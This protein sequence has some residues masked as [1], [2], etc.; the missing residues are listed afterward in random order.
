MLSKARDTHQEPSLRDYLD[1][2]ARHWKVLVFVPIVA[3]L[4]AFAYA[5]FG[6]S[7]YRSEAIVSLSNEALALVRSDRVLDAVAQETGLMSGSNGDL[8]IVRRK[9]RG[10]IRTDVWQKDTNLYRLVVEQ[11]TEQAAQEVLQKLIEALIAES[12]PYGNARLLLEK[13]R[14]AVEHSL[15]ELTEALGRRKVIDSRAVADQSSIAIPMFLVATGDS[16]TDLTAAI[17][18]K[19]QELLSDELTL[20]GRL[21]QSNILSN[22]TPMGRSGP[23]ALFVATTV[24]IAVGGLLLLILLVW[25]AAGIE[26]IELRLR[27]SRPSDNAIGH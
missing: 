2:V 8:T 27:K 7:S 14:Q 5:N 10:S 25:R 3:G 15:N 16:I 26:P 20:K 13:R 17:E 4:A 24:A 11:P 9:L 21:S 18:A 19:S 6:P 22:P 23:V 1:V 12:A